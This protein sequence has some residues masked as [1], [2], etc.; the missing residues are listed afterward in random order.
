MKGAVRWDKDKATGFITVLKIFLE[1]LGK[2]NETHYG[3]LVLRSVHAHGQGNGKI[4]DL[5]K[6]G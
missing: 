5:Q 2:C 6:K 1:V 4:C 3:F